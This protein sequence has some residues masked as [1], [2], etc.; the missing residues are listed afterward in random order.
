MP[1]TCS[2]RSSTSNVEAGAVDKELGSLLPEKLC[3]DRLICPMAVRDTVLDVAFVSPEEMGVVDELQ[4]MTGLRINPMIAP[5]SV[6]E[7][8]LDVLYRSNRDSKAIGEGT[9]EF[10]NVEEDRDNDDENILDL[11]VTP[12]ADANGRIVRM[13]N[14]ILEQ[15]LRNRASDIHLEPFEDGC[16][17]RLRIDGDASRTSA[18]V[19]EHL[20]HDRLPVQGAGEDGYRRE[21]HPPGRCDRAPH[22][23]QADRPPRQH[24]PH[25]PRRE[26]GDANSRQ[27]GDPAG[28]DR[29][30]PG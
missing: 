24:R 22:R 19:E 25:R 28:P 5:L 26:D 13:V 10:D 9:E 11:D 2:S 14:Q 17:F 27:R 12:P 18:A 29:P 8:R 3:V 1:K 15:A 23:R 20:H 16:K 4:L 21:A 7:S 30:G 6:V